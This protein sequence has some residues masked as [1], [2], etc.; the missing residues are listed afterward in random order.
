[1]PLAGKT[2]F[3]LDYNYLLPMMVCRCD[4]MKCDRSTSPLDRC[5]AWA[6]GAIILH[7]YELILFCLY[8]DKKR[9]CV[10]HTRDRLVEMWQNE[11]KQKMML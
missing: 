8:P 4:L 7:R 11:S 9:N 1:V 2:S 3:S 10:E 5:V 6:K